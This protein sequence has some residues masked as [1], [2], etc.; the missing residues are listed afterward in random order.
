MI[1]F[2]ISY[3]KKDNH[4]TS[5]EGWRIYSKLLQGWSEEHIEQKCK[6][7]SEHICSI[8]K[9][10]KKEKK[11]KNDKRKTKKRP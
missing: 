11:G 7:P 9:V 6:I 3:I 8:W 10:E 4:R 2:G 5:V 1:Q